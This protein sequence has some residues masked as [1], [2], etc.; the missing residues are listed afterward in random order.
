M[1]WNKKKTYGTKPTPR[2]RHTANY[3]NGKLYIFGGNDC[4]MSFNNIFT[5]WIEI[6]VPNSTLS[7]DMYKLLYDPT[8]SDVTL[9]IEDGKY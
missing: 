4:D 8:F 5:L 1:I 6:H 3:L 9:V 7:S 2:C